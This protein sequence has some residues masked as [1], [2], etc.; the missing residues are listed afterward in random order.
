MKITLT[1]DQL[2]AL[3]AVDI[4]YGNDDLVYTTDGANI[5]SYTS[6][7]SNPPFIVFTLAEPLTI[8]DFQLMLPNRTMLPVNSLD[9]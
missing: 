2:K 4:N 3:L 9:D 6:V 8:G 5:L 7:A 1:V